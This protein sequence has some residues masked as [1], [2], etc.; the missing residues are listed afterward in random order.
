MQ[1]RQGVLQRGVPAPADLHGRA[2]RRRHHERLLRWSRARWRLRVLARAS[3]S[4]LVDEMKRANNK[5]MFT[6]E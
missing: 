4:K 2:G 1:R 5:K 3:N 6:L